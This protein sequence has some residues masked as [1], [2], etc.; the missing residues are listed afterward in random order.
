MLLEHSGYDPS[1]LTRLG[2]SSVTHL[3][4][5]SIL[6]LA[7][8]AG[9]G[10]SAYYLVRLSSHEEQ[11]VIAISYATGA[12]AFYFLFNLNRLLVTSGGFGV[13]RDGHGLVGWQPLTARTV[14]LSLIA[15]AAS[16]PLLLWV[17]EGALDE[18]VQ[19]RIEDSVQAYKGQLLNSIQAREIPLW[20]RSAEIEDLLGSALSGRSL[21][22]PPTANS[23]RRA[24]PQGDGRRKALLIGAQRYSHQKPLKTPE[25]DVLKMQ[26]LLEKIGFEVATS[27]DQSGNEINLGIDAYLRTLRPGDISL[28][29]YSGH[30]FQ[31]NGHNYIVPVDFDYRQNFNAIRITPIIE[32]VG[33]TS[34]RLQV[35]L[36]DACRGFVARGSDGT[37]AQGGLAEIQGSENS[38]I[39]MAAQPGQN[40]YDGPPGGNSPFTQAILRHI[41]KPGDIDALFR[42]VRKDV[43]ESTGRLGVEPQRPT[44][45]SQ[46]T[47]KQ[48]QLAS[49]AFL[50]DSPLVLGSRSSIVEYAGCLPSQSGV[51]PTGGTSRSND[52]C[53]LGKLHAVKHAL[54]ILDFQKVVPLAS[55]LEDYRQSLTGSSFI[56]ER[57]RMQWSAE[58]PFSILFTLLASIIMFAGSVLRDLFPTALR[59]Y[60]K[61]RHEMSQGFLRNNHEQANAQT[62]RFL[63]NF[64]PAYDRPLDVF[65]VPDDPFYDSNIVQ[66]DSPARIQIDGQ[67]YAD[68][69]GALSGR[70]G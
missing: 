42:E 34:P 68:L 26:A 70:S 17:R 66:N 39:A 40:A 8:C 12:I 30:G 53:L 52:A 1:V 4:V 57:W 27:I 23:G 48:V 2:Q 25:N 15:I 19:Q 33:K 35:L 45:T 13:G 49:R 20:T 58:R 18:R 51:A 59:E 47:D 31:H 24:L 65:R 29:Y 62:R 64:K 54:Q 36:L 55:R 6:T 46:L 5:A 32:Y 50:K 60:E 14:V 44:I 10:A 38:F 67:N 63:A 7:A 43:I 69:L 21:G 56:E 41:G 61:I 9:V 3:S 11:F 28:V 16:Q 37:E 22:K